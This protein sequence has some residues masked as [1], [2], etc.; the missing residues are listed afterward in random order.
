[1]KNRTREEVEMSRLIDDWIRD[2]GKEIDQYQKDLQKKTG[3]DLVSLSAA[4]CGKKVAD[5]VKLSKEEKIAVIPITSGEGIIGTFAESVAAIV[6]AMDFEV[7]VTSHT[8]VAGMVEAHDRGAKILFLS[9]DD[10]FVAI[11]MEKNIIADNNWATAA[12]F[13]TALEGL[14]GESLANKNVLVIGCGIVGREI[15]GELTL[16]KANAWAYDS[17]KVILNEIENE[18]YSV[19]KSAEAI[20]KY[21]YIIDATCKGD[22]LEK[23]MLHPDAV[24]ATPGVPLSLN[25]EA[26]DIY[27]DRTV[28]DYLNIGVAV[29]VGMQAE[30]K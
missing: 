12:G 1:M 6:R 3:F 20:K 30:S 19:E 28:H 22:W 8:D 27:K 5:I 16:R 15:L 14:A 26:W 23:E 2:I 29:M 17:N 10:R 18:G 25:S 21:S 4:A 11:N 13:V 9:D 7:F 24:I